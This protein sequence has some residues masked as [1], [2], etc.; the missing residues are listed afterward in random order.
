M[1]RR[2][3]LRLFG[4]AFFWGGG[5]GGYDQ[6]NGKLT[7]WTDADAIFVAESWKNVDVADESLS[8]IIFYNLAPGILYLMMWIGTLEFFNWELLSS[9]LNDFLVP[10]VKGEMWL[11]MFIVLLIL[12]FILNSFVHMWSS[13]DY[14]SWS[15]TLRRKMPFCSLIHPL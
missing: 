14:C 8:W 11:L 2:L 5:E 1:W 3:K 13:M 4:T 6:G 15:Y 9:S 7:M 12:L 10:Y